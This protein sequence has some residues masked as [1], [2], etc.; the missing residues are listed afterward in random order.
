MTEFLASYAEFSVGQNIR[1]PDGHKVTVQAIERHF[2]NMQVR[3][4]DAFS[5]KTEW[6][7]I[8]RWSL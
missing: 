3:Y 7:E 6:E 2:G 4:H 1:R 5:G 8:T